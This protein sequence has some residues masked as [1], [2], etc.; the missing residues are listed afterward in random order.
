MS[1]TTKRCPSCE[2]RKWTAA[3]SRDGLCD[4]CAEHTK[5]ASMVNTQ[6]EAR[7]RAEGNKVL[8]SLGGRPWRLRVWENL[9]W[10][11]SCELGNKGEISIYP[12]GGGLSVFASTSGRSDE[13]HWS[14]AKDSRSP[15]LA[16]RRKIQAMIQ[17][18]DKTIRLIVLARRGLFA[19]ETRKH[20]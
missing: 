10:H 13:C 5:G 17:R 2:H 4:E 12:S 9:G 7:A 16:L 19:C 8:R 1:L 11:W 15:A 20:R 14:E 3:R 18:R 6:A